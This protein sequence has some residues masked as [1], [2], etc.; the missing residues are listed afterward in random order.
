MRK[1]QP[2]TKSSAAHLLP[3]QLRVNEA[4]T[5][6]TLAGASAA[7]GRS[8]SALPALIAVGQQ[9]DACMPRDSNAL[10]DAGLSSH[11]SDLESRVE[12]LHQSAEVQYTALTGLL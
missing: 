6:N 9:P 4:L 5:R 11:L 8:C 3:Q 10:C 12:A 7:A 1:V 2:F